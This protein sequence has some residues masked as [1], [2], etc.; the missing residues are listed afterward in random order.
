MS[1]CGVERYIENVEEELDMGREW[2]FDQAT[3]TLVYMPNST[4][5]TA[6]HATTGAPTGDFV[7][8]KP[9]TRASSSGGL[10]VV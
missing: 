1:T 10:V 2:Y 6:V 7:A 3:Q 9:V 4:D 5:A 8:T